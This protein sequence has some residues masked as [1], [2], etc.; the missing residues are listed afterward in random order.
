LGGEKNG[1]R[2]FRRSKLTPS[3]RAERKEGRQEGIVVGVV[4]K[5]HT[6]SG[7]LSCEM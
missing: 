6:S 5:S 4:Y 2:L 7:I 3:S 1:G